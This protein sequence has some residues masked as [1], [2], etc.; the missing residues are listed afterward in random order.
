MEHPN[1]AI[2]RRIYE[3]FNDRDFDRGLA[4]VATDAAWTNLPTGDTFHGRDDFRRNYVQW[5]TAFP[6]G[7]CE[8]VHVVATDDYAVVEFI[9]RG[10]NTGPLQT[11]EGEIPPTG[12]R[13]DIPFCD[14]MRI[15]DGL[16]TNGRSYFDMATMMRQL[17]LMP[18]ARAETT[19]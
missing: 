1:A 4:V 9:G 2:A 18:E 7:R 13:V 15:E 17:G 14:V 16:I 10:S 8:D 12:R 11:P 5:S 19:H 6:D 3:G